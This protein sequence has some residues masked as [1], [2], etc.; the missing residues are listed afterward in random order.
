[1]NMICSSFVVAGFNE[2]SVRTENVYAAGRKGE[3]K[4]IITK[5]TPRMKTEVFTP[6]LRSAELFCLVKN[7]Q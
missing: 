5:A 4:A 7:I 1:M 6:K 2:I 3:S